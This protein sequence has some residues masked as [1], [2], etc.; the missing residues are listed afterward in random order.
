MKHLSL[1][2]TVLLLTILC[3]GILVF[4]NSTA[5]IPTL[6]ESKQINYVITE[7]DLTTSLVFSS[8]INDKTIKTYEDLIGKTLSCEINS[9]QPIN[10]SCIAGGGE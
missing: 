9:N 7:E 4:V 6:K 3:F 5:L 8:S 10:L 1:K 2:L